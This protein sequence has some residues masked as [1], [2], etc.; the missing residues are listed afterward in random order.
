[1]G[2]CF[3]SARMALSTL[4]SYLSRMSWPTSA[5]ISRRGLPMPTR[6]PVNLVIVDRWCGSVKRSA[7]KLCGLWKER[8]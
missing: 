5:E 7:Y 2:R 4:T 1:M 3:S 6:E 8:H